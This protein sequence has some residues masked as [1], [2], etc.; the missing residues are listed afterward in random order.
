MYAFLAHKIKFLDI[1]RIIELSLKNMRYIAKPSL[2]E[3][4]KVD[5]ETKS[6]SHKLIKEFGGARWQFYISFYSYFVYQL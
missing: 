3:I 6:Y 5:E 4:L 1:E 2:E